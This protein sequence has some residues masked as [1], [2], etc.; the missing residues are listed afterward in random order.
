[1]TFAPPGAASVKLDVVIVAGFIASENDAV[2]GDV[3]GMSFAPL[4][5][6]VCV[7][8]GETWSGITSIAVTSGSSADP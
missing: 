4:T 6:D 1:M 5:G 8:V 3:V 7:T 2:T